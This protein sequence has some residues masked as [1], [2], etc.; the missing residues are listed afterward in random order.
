MSRVRI[1]FQSRLEPELHEWLKLEKPEERITATASALS[2]NRGDKVCNRPL[3][4]Q[5]LL[6]E[7]S[8]RSVRPR[9]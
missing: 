4:I 9:R 5:A 2:S 3:F 6:P 7:F 8:Q 1:V